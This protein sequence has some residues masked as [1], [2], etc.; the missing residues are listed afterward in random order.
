MDWINLA[1]DRDKRPVL[2]N[3]KINILVSIP[4][5]LAQLRNY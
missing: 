3:T 4:K 2:V 5:I 1:P